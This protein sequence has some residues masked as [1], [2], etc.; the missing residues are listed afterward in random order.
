MPASKSEALQGT[1]DL[2]VQNTLDSMGPLHGFG[3]SMRIQQDSED[4]VRLNQGT[5]YPAVLRLEQHGWIAS[6]WGFSEHNRKA[7]N[8]S[9]T[10]AGR[11]QLVEETESWGRMPAMIN[12]VL[13]AS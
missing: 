11:R 9:L 7:K 12:R 8:Y 4:L 13:R 5:I 10:C 6:K 3:I 1:L 2:V